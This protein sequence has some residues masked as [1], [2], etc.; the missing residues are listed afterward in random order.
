M[1][2][3]EIAS[4]HGLTRTSALLSS[5][6]L[7]ARETAEVLA[8]SHPSHSELADHVETDSDLMEVFVPYEKRPLSEMEA[9]RFEIY[10]HGRE[11]EGY[12]IFPDV[13]RRVRRL[14]E[15]LRLSPRH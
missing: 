7:R 5:P 1:G 3:V 8:A 13:V 6:L 14:F 4:T 12:E 2:S 15:R 9:I 10:S 11:A